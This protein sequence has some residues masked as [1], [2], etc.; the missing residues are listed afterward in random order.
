MIYD[1][2]NSNSQ[3]KMRSPVISLLLCLLL[4]NLLLAKTCCD[5]PQVRL[6]P[7]DYG[8]VTLGRVFSALCS[9]DLE[10]I[11]LQFQGDGI[12]FTLNLNSM[13]FISIVHKRIFAK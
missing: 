8:D 13:C 2:Q 11:I 5:E 3:L 10:L 12:T 7:L 4:P 9:W 6:L 1:N